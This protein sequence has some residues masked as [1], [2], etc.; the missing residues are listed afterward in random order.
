[1]SVMIYLAFYIHHPLVCFAVWSDTLYQSIIHFSQFRFTDSLENLLLI[2][3]LGSTFS[4]NQLFILRARLQYCPSSALAGRRYV[5]SFCVFVLG[6]LYVVARIIL[7]AVALR[8]LSAIPA[9]YR[10]SVCRMGGFDTTYLAT[11]F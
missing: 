5:A 3:H 9:K 7:L 10:P 11:Y 4:D 6:P 1:M 2:H 8:S